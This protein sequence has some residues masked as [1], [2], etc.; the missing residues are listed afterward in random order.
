MLQFKPITIEDKKTITSYSRSTQFLNCDLAFSN[1]CS[2]RFYYDSEFVVEDDFLLI[3][4]FLRDKNKRHQVYMIPLGTG[5]LRRTIEKIEKDAW[6]HH[7]PLCILGVTP[8]GKNQLENLFPGEFTFNAE[9]NY[10]DYIYLR[11]DLCTL[12]GKKFQSKRNHVNKFK[13]SYTY[14]YLP[15]TPEMI[16]ECLKLEQ[17]W[18]LANH[19]EK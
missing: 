9:R 8:D 15:I 4:F 12:K 19:I 11:K 18:V 3:R 1:M 17:K 10:F 5:D 13:K 7:H 2:W 16:P 6:D 14:T